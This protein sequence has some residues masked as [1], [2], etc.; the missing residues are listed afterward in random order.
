MIYNSGLSRMK[1]GRTRKNVSRSVMGRLLPPVDINNSN[2]LSELDKRISVGPITL[3]FVYADWCGHCQ[4]FKPNMDELEK[5][6]G[7]S[8]QTVRLRDDML[9]QSSL[10][11]TKINGYPSLLLIDK[12]GEPT[13][14]K[15]KNGEVTNTI[16][17][18]NDLNKMKAI[19]KNAG[20]PQGISLL[21]QGE[22]ASATNKNIV[23]DRLSNENVNRQNT[24]LLNSNSKPLQRSMEPVVVGGGMVGGG[25]LWGHLLAASQKLAPAAAL[26]LGASVLN[27]KRRVKKATRKNRR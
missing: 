9:P 20:T 17:E 3:V 7:R 22:E 23:S 12:N 13:V 16:P 6:S 26:F 19:V 10:K 18:Y 25:G 1:G 24:T 11:N 14:F 5:L 4:R 21:S 27:N 15:D 2:S 8:V